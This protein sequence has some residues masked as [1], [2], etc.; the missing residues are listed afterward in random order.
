MKITIIETGYV[1]ASL[2]P[3]FGTY[4]AMFRAMFDA[5]GKDYTYDV[6]RVLE[7]DEFPHLDDVEGVAITGSPAG[8]YEDHAWLPPLRD[9]IRTVH[10][11]RIPML[12]ICF[13]HQIIADA[14]GGVVK[15]SDKGW[16]IGRHSYSVVK[17]PDFMADA[18]DVL[19]VACSHQ[20]QVIEPPKG[21]EVILST[22]FTPHAG[23]FYD[24]GRTLTFQP[25]PEFSEDYARA[26]AVM[27]EEILGKEL[28][29][30]CLSSF[31][32]TSDS[33]VLSRYISEFFIANSR[34]EEE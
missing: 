9:F 11:A 25:H 19:A 26:L 1:P 7:G 8:V 24:T 14:L 10:A 20:D 13:G 30:N 33:A 23:L 17:R 16:G 15:K 22:P 29:D 6:V 34:S 3:Q 4:P 27:R 21:A 28:L 12:G 18:P 5:S 31:E 32:I 2:R